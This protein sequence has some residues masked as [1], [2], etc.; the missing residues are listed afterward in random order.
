V[1]LLAALP[2]G[3][4]L[5]EVGAPALELGDDALEFLAG[6]LECRLAHVPGRLRLPPGGAG[7]R[8]RL[9]PLRMREPLVPP[10][11]PSSARLR[12]AGLDGRMLRARR[13]SVPVVLPFAPRACLLCQRG[14]RNPSGSL[15]SLA[16]FGSRPAEPGSTGGAAGARSGSRRDV[17]D[18]GAEAAHGQLDPDAPARLERGGDAHDAFVRADDRVAAVE[19]RPR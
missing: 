1:E 2:Q 11:T 10:L 18:S 14:P 13:S 19:R 4:S 16:A 8:R 6:L 12:R 5:L 7:L 9:T 17:L 15:T 3:K